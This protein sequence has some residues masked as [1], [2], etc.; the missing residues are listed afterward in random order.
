MGP[1]DTYNLYNASVDVSY[2]LDLLGGGRRQIE[3][4]QA[5]I[6]Y[7][8]YIYE[9]T[10]LTLAANIVTAAI[11]EASLREQIDVTRAIL[12]AQQRQLDV[13]QKQFEL[14]AVSK[15]EVLAQETELAMTKA[16]MPPLEKQLDLN[17][18]ALSV[19]IGQFPGDG[20]LPEF[21]LESL[22]LPEELP[23]SLTLESG[24]PTPRC[25]RL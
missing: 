11:Q 18:H 23:V 9:A 3:A 1:S 12:A 15:T 20:K 5:Q 22:H 16:G 13:I 8:S 25:P 24:A 4:Y 2:T 6:D 21:S 17:R 10:Y 14:G 19:L 7:Q